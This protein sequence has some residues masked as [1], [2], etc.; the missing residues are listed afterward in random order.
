MIKCLKCDEPTE[1]PKFCSRTC[2]GSYNSHKFVKRKRKIHYCDCGNEKKYNR[3]TC[4]ECYYVG[5]IKWK[6]D[7]TIK[8]A[9]EMCGR[10]QT[11]FSA[12]RYQARQKLK[13]SPKKCGKCGYDK[14]VEVCHV[15]A[16][17]DFPLDTRISVVN[18][19]D[20]L[21]LL[22]PNCHWEFDNL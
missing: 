1:N 16:L 21:I 22:C 9:T 17:S 15:Q 4:L 13:E 19:V 7:I 20:N 11:V 6:G 12:I 5:R 3:K 2:A 8:E 10:K 14:Y 18:S